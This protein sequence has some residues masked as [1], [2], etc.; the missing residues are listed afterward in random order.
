M[1]QKTGLFMK[2]GTGAVL[3][4]AIGFVVVAVLSN[5]GRSAQEQTSPPPSSIEKKLYLFF[6][7][8]LEI[9]RIWCYNRAEVIQLS[10]NLR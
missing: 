8:T 6:L 3:V 5:T 7:I 2:I 1:E 10:S 9:I 4:L